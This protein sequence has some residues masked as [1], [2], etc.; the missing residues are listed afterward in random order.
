MPLLSGVNWG[1]IHL[2]LHG[3]VLGYVGAK[4]QFKY[5][6]T[7]TGRHDL[8]FF[9]DECVELQRSFLDAC[10]KGDD[11]KG[12]L[13]PGKVPSVNLCIRKGNPG[14]GNPEEERKTFPRRMENE[15]PLA[16]TQ[17][18]DYHL[19]PDLT[20]SLQKPRVKGAIKWEAPGDSVR[21]RSAPLSHEVEITGHPMARLSLALSPRGQSSPSEMD[22]F[23]TLRHYDASNQEIFYTGAAGEPIPVVRG[24]LRVSLRKTVD[25]PTPLSTFMPERNYYSTDRQE[26]AVGT[27]YTVDVEIWP[28]SVVLMPNETLELQISSSDS[29]NVGVFG[30]NHREDRVL[31]KLEGYNEL[32]FDPR[33]E[34]FLRL[35]I[36][37]QER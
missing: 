28:T 24:W 5:M 37:P 11:R 3:S 29:E 10:L 7:M 19:L 4:S 31:E 1:A 20:M 34:N 35:P 13:V 17:Y 25:N 16:R 15:W 32:H 33:Y 12:W 9:Y 2:H 36:I 21:F 23:V 6:Y 27:V 8:P 30:H 14:Y 18:T 22:V 26:V